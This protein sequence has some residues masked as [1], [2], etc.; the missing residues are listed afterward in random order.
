MDASGH[1]GDEGRRRLR[2]STVSCQTS[3][4]PYV[5]EWRNPVGVKSHY[6]TASKVVVG[7]ERGELK[8]LSIRRKINQT[9]IP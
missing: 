3:V 9:E 8:H 7:G 2:K 5:S 4:D 1:N 6:P